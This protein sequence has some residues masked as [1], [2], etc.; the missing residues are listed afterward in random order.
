MFRGFQRSGVLKVHEVGILLEAD[1]TLNLRAVY[2]SGAAS[3][4][5]VGWCGRWYQSDGAPESHIVDQA[6]S[7]EACGAKNR[8]GTVFV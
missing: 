8:Q 2:V 7:A 4:I 5:M 6:R 1:R 3:E